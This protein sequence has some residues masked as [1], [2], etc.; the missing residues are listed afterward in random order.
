MLLVISV[1]DRLYSGEREHSF[2]YNGKRCRESTE[3]GRMK[4]EA[5]FGRGVM[6]NV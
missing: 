3:N 6:V 2:D 4:E 5:D 1:L